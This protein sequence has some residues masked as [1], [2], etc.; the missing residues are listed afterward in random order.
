MK[1]IGA[2]TLKV[3]IIVTL[4]LVSVAAV[5]FTAISSYFITKNK[6]AEVLEISREQVLRESTRGIDNYYNSISN[7]VRLLSKDT[8]VKN[9]NNIVYFQFAKDVLANVKETDDNFTNVYYGL[10]TGSFYVNPIPLLEDGFD[11]RTQEWYLRAKD[12][13]S[14]IMVT[15]PYIDPISG[16]LV[17]TLSLSVENGDSFVGVVGID[18]QLNSLV[19]LI[20]DYEEGDS[21]YTF[22]LNH[23]GI[24]MSHPQGQY[25]GSS[26]FADT[27]SIWEE[28]KT[29]T[30]GTGTAMIG[31][32]EGFISYAT[33][34]TTGW[35]VFTF[36]D[37]S[38]LNDRTRAILIGTFGAVLVAVLISGIGAVLFSNPIAKNIKMILKGFNL[39]AKGDMTIRLEVKSGDE[40]ETIGQ[41]F[42]E[43]AE[44]L[45]GVIKTVSNSSTVVLH[46]AGILTEMAEETNNSVSEV[47][48]A[49]EEIARGT[50]EQAANA[51]DG[52]AS[53]HEL[54]NEL[55]LIIQ[56]T[57]EMDMLSR[58]TDECAKEG[59]T[60][61]EDLS[62]KSDNT[63]ESTTKVSALVLE[64]SESVH[65]INQIS[66]TIDDIA[67]Q[68]NLL[69]LN[70]SIEAARAGESGRGFGV[71]AN[72]I[73][74]LADQSRNSTIQIKKIIDDII[75][76]TDLSVAAMEET[77]QNV[78][79]QVDLVHQ[80]RVAFQQIVESVSIL[81]EQVGMV[82]V[83]S[84]NISDKKDIAVGEI[85]NISAISE[86]AAS[87]T[88]EVTAST[89]EISMTM[90]EIAKHTAK[91]SQLSKDLK[92]SIDVFKI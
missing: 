42:N 73:R 30:S 39:F 77:K 91:L 52:A 26:N 21:G 2:K 61:V 79:D 20:S 75:K 63:L 59:L 74:K 58:A 37:K 34:E 35:K 51:S 29:N 92:K 67:E 69:A 18:L 48:R 85:E 16:K 55:T 41:H 53:I 7:T 72:E 49:I 84:E 22:I 80:T 64:T 83:K 50:S 1:K 86:E 36:S 31:T 13:P 44:S 28:A 81:A 89:E 54:A 23:D 46:N 10:E 24:V 88:E 78:N 25:V 11:A 8:N 32:E 9:S 14:T 57:E 76:K 5:F 62:D 45:S 3:K 43:M 87:A 82:K 15:G 27:M 6:L 56:G 40:F 4:L 90:D 19:H 38:E 65:Q 71:V 33:S 60:Y 47:A 70:A 66:N 12:N 68:T 17:I